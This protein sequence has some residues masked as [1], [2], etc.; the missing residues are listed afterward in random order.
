MMWILGDIGMYY[1]SIF[2]GESLFP[3]PS[4]VKGSLG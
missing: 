4:F 1:Y 2:V 3:S